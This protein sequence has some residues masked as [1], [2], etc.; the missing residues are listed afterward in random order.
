MRDKETYEVNIESRPPVVRFTADQISTETPNI[1]LFDGT[2]TYDPDAPDDQTLKYQ[3]YVNDKPVQLTGTNSNN[4]RGE[5]IFPEVGSYQVE[6]H[7]VDDQ[8]KTSIYKK[9]VNIKSLLSVQLNIR[10]LVVVR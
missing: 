9:S 6:L 7:V 4:S 2:S 5:Y 1:Y 8:G 10:P 3:W